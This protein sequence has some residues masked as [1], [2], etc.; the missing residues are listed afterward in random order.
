MRPIQRAKTVIALAALALGAPVVLADAAAQAPPHAWL[1]GSWSGGLFPTPSGLTTQACLSQPVV[2]FTR[3]VVMRATLTDQ[4]YI[5]RVVE[6]ARTS[7]NVTEF[8]FTPAPATNG[9]LG[10]PTAAP[11]GFGCADPNALQVQRKS[12][13]EITFP[14]CPDFPNPLVR[15]PPR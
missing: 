12:D 2:V 13:N 15:C 7:G 14:D 1:F 8:R 5:Q 9:L 3:D 6:T 11:A 4:L 10:T